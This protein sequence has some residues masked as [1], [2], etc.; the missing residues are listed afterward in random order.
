[1]E[2]RLKRRLGLLERDSALE[3]SDD[4]YPPAAARL[5]VVAEAGA[6]RVHFS[7]HHNRNPKGRRSCG[8][9][10]VE[11]RLADAHDGQWVAIHENLFADHVGVGG[12]TVQPVSIAEDS[13]RSGARCW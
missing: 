7:V 11:T 10:S 3:A 1:M 2:V 12:I 5:E 6:D 4:V 9:G 8:I 13:V